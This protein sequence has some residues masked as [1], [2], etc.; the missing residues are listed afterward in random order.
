MD[1]FNP[2][3]LRIEID[4]SLPAIRIV[5][6]L[7]EPIE[8]RGKPLALRMD[9]SPEPISEALEKW[10][11]KHGV[12]RRFIRPGRPMQNGLIE[13]FNRTYREEILDATCPK[14]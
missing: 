14:H 1:D 5:R 11:E 10:A 7:E 3:A 2:E 9:K 13:R 8:V 12:E 6:A 4:S